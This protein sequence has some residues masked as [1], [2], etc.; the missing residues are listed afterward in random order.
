MAKNLS[1]Q[2]FDNYLLIQR[3]GNGSFGEVYLANHIYHKTRVAIKI[4]YA[5][6]D[7]KNLMDFLREARAFHLEHPN[8]VRIKDF[9][10]ENNRPFLVMNYTPNGNLRQRHPK[11]TQV[12][13]E[14][15]ISYARQIAQA[16]Q[17]IHDEGIV[18]RDIKPENM[19]VGLSDE[20]LLADF[21]ITTTSYTWDSHNEQVARGTP[22]Y[23]APEQINAQAVRASDQYA[24]GA[25][26]YEWL[27]GAPLFEGMRDDV[28]LKHMMTPPPPLRKKLPTISPQAEEIVM[29]MLMKRP[30]ERF[31][32]MDEFI[33]AL[34][35]AQSSSSLIKPLVFCKHTD[36][37]RVV[38]WSPDSRYIASAGRDKVVY[39]WNV[40]TGEPISA[41]HGH[42]E[43]IWSLAWSP[44]SR[45]IVSAGTDKTAQVWEASTGAGS[46][47][48]NG[49]KSIIRAVIWSP[50]GR[51]IASTGDDK[52]IQVWEAKTGKLV[53]LYRWHK[54]SVC[55]LAWSPD[56]TCIVSG[57][58]E[59]IVH[60]WK[61]LEDATLR[62]FYGHT[63]RI[64]SL[65]WSSDST[66]IASASDDKTV[67]IWEVTTGVRR[68]MYTAH[69]KA[70]SAVAWSPKGEAIASAS[71]DTT[72]HI[73]KMGE[74]EPYMVY[75]GHKGWV[76]TLSWSPTS[77]Y[78]VSGSLDKTVHILCADG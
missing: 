25:V 40:T 35:G 24:L 38:A 77:N 37:V 28:L 50:D 44:D 68:Y 63:D 76:N 15:I 59:G 43:E 17:Y 16:L 67:S 39:V 73:W 60:M 46:I 69:S 4:L 74:L 19:L 11:G 55:A 31:A 18:H 30:E 57:G 75:H 49:H 48:H 65:A 5:C 2:R 70:V 72:V 53:F 27:T 61:I 10:V 56:S 33:A 6:I 26:M 45:F 20:I 42:V 36:G 41:Y 29:K 23:I 51:Y 52:T 13:W 78:L 62:Q 1:G 21:G 9:G 34:N 7:T 14:T 71:W 22:L 8:I 32:G 3:L 58:E 66:Y 12:P 64:T 47:M 54:D